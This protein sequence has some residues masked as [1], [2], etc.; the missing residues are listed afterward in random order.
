[1]IGLQVAL[2]LAAGHAYGRSPAVPDQVSL[3]GPNPPGLERS[4]ISELKPSADTTCLFRVGNPG[5]YGFI[6]NA[7]ILVIPMQFE[8]APDV[9]SEGLAAARIGGSWRYVDATGQTVLKVAYDRAGPFSHGMAPVRAADGK[10]GFIDRTGVER[11]PVR[12]DKVIGFRDGEG[13]VGVETEASKARR[14]VQ[15]VGMTE[16]DWQALDL[17][18]NA[19]EWT[20]KPASPSTASLRP[21]RNDGVFGFVDAQGREVVPPKFRQ[22]RQQADGLCAALTTEGWLFLDAEGNTVV[23]PLVGN[24]IGVGY[25]CGVVGFLRPNREGW[26]TVYF[27]RN[28]AQIWPPK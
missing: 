26:D 14:E 24:L 3:R 21:F 18:G 20:K 12:F 17:N 19:I 25:R 13:W 6:N 8:E 16:F 4:D 22:A 7:G 23:G 15:D 28:G 1:M 2:G 9:F 5:S 11:V 27:D 10:W